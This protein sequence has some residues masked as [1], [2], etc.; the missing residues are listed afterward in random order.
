MNC[1]QDSI[2][3]SLASLRRQATVLAGGLG[4]LAQRASVYHH[5]FKHSGAN[6]CFPLL[7]AHGALW[8][9]G[10]FRLGMRVGSILSWGQVIAGDDRSRQE[11][12]KRLTKLANDFRDINRRVC[13]ETYFIY[14]L[15]STDLLLPA[16]ERSIP[17]DL[18]DHMARCHAARREGRTLSS[19]ERRSLFE[20]FFLWEQATIV[21]PAVAQAFNEFD[22][23]IVKAMAQRPKISFAYF[24]R[25]APLVFRDF[26]DTDER[27]EKGLMAFD[28]AEAAGW[29]NVDDKIRSYGIL[30]PGFSI[31][32]NSYFRNLATT[33]GLSL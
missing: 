21:G 28:L 33:P 11:L 12:M 26:S 17:L 8:A 22:W 23:P 2:D 3:D 15:S 4:D 30:P 7:A 25:S 29:D 24:P 1:E 16:A 5:L 32:P 6:H 27:I 9:G 14:Y 20:A 31:D 10:Y 18:L 19:R 13:V